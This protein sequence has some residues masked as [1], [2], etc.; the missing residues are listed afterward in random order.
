MN[1]QLIIFKMFL[2][3]LFEC[4]VRGFPGGSVVKNPPA[5]AGDLVYILMGK[6]PHAVEQLRL[7]VTSVEPVL[8]SPGATTTEALAP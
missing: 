8:K 1:C 4:I 5:N 6:I 2:K 7:C 3:K